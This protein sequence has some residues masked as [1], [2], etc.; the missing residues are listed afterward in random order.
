[1]F[2]SLVALLA[3]ISP[4]LSIAGIVFYFCGTPLITIIVAAI[5]L[6]DSLLQ[7]TVGQ[8]NNLACECLA[9]FIGCLIS[10]FAHLPILPC[11][12]IAVC[13]EHVIMTLGGL[14]FMYLKIR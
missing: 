4:L 9:L 5:S 3:W 7:R 1:M 8:Q 6:T 13:F 12:A 11:L 2:V 10:G 14:V